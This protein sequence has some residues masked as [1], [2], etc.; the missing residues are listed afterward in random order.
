MATRST[1]AGLQSDS[2]RASGGEFRKIESPLEFY[3]T[4]PRNIGSNKPITGEMRAYAFRVINAI[5]A[6]NEYKPKPID[7][8]E[9]TWTRSK[10]ATKAEN[11]FER[12]YRYEQAVEK[13]RSVLVDKYEK[14]VSAFENV[15]QGRPANASSG[16]SGSFLLN[17]DKEGAD[18]SWQHA[19]SVL[20]FIQGLPK[21][22]QTLDW[23]LGKTNS[24]DDLR[25]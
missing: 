20:G 15:K 7:E 3:E 24:N 12:Q 4:K 25:A 14:L 5:V 2:T 9:F 18:T 22:N 23:L 16:A 10:D 13:E 11:D 19:T 21:N 17:G 6:L 8:M 1:S